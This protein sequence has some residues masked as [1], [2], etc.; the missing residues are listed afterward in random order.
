MGGAGSITLS[1]STVNVGSLTTD[2]SGVIEMLVGDSNN[3]QWVSGSVTLNE[4][5]LRIRLDVVPNEA[6]PV[7]KVMGGMTFTATPTIE[8]RTDGPIPLGVQYPLFAV[9]GSAPSSIP[10]LAGEGGVLKWV[11]P[12]RNTLVWDTGTTG[13]V[14]LIR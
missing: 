9:A 13:T 2:G 6:V 10:H 11:G 12:R 5:T 3:S 7:V 8:I 14:L 4:S 1:S